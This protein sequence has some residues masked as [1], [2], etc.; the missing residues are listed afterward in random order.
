MVF[1]VITTF[2]AI[3]QFPYDNACV[4]DGDDATDILTNYVGKYFIEDG[5]GHITQVKITPDDTVYTFCNQ[6]LLDFKNISFPF[7]WM[8]PLQSLYTRIFAWTT[9][10]IFIISVFLFLTK[11]AQ[12]VAA[13]FSSSYKVSQKKNKLFCHVVK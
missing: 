11:V 2:L 7:E 3:A 12:F 1:Y 4:Y 8:S 9:V 6:D 13:M 5:A 10:A